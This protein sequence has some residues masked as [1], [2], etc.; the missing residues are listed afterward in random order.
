MGSNDQLSGGGRAGT[1]TRD[2]YALDKPYDLYGQPNADM[3]Q[4]LDEMLTDLFRRSTRVAADVSDIQ[5][6][7]G[8]GDVTGPSGATADNIAVFDGVTGKLI[9]DGGSNIASVIAAAT[10]A[11]VQATG[12]FAIT[13]SIPQ[14]QLESAFSTPVTLVTAQGANTVIMPISW[15]PEVD[16][17]TAY[18]NNPVWSL[19][20]AVAPTQGLLATQIMN[21]NSAPV[22][23]LL[24]GTNNNPA[25]HLFT[26]TTTDPRNS[27]LVFRLNGDLTGGGAATAKIHLVYTPVPTF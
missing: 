6:S 11:A 5:N 22:T 20:Y 15:W 17:T 16:V 7:G 26:Y 23:R 27:D 19:A 10:A 18:S 13:V 8:S 21:T 12:V 25:D 4:Q 24:V 2:N 14:V 3:V 1:E 9:K